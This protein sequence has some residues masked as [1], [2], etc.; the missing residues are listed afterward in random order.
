MDGG[1]SMDKVGFLEESSG[2]K[3]STRLVFV[4]GSVFTLLIAAYMCYTKCGTPIEIGTFLG[5]GIA[6]F[7]GTKYF[8]TK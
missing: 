4:L 1:S 3:S 7:G 2:V 6:A 5:M 8:G